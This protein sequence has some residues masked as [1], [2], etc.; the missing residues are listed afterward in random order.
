[1]PPT[2]PKRVLLVEGKTEERL[3]PELMERRGVVWE[4]E[5]K[6]PREFAVKIKTA[7][8]LV[9]KPYLISSNLKDSDLVA[10]GI[11][12]DAD[13]MENNADQ[14]WGKL[15]TRCSDDIEIA[16]PDNA[17]AGGFITTLPNGIRFGVWMMPNNQPPG[18]LETFLLSLLKPEEATG[19]LFEHARSSVEKAKELGAP[20]KSVHRDK[21][22]FHT[23]L[24]W[25]DE[26]G[27]QL[28]EAIKFNIL[29]ASSPNADAFVS[30]FRGLFQV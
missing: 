5:P 15:R 1:M 20:F 13:D 14:R 17:P 9:T 28:H 29:D 30:W 6:K 7:D 11:V 24:S 2:I 22:L 27:A 25:Q 26:P 16:L 23:W 12:F 3:I 8:G 21:A 19:T 18:M 10:F 4:P